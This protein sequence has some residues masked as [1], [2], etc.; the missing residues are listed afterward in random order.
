[1]DNK[2]GALLEDRERGRQVE[3]TENLS[4]LA[5]KERIVQMAFKSMGLA[6]LVYVRH[7]L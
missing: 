2:I 4:R 5:K 6:F 3:F 1:M 7:G